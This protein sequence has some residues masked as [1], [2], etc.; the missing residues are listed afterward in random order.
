MNITLD[1]FHH[2]T[3]TTQ[4]KDLE[5]D[6]KLTDCELRPVTFY[7]IDAI[8][9]HEEDGKTYGTI[10]CNGR[11]F[12]ASLSYGELWEKLNKIKKDESTTRQQLLGY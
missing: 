2:S 10:H 5:I 9:Q 11:E 4:F 7:T 3:K 6:Y 8:S 12:I 1:I